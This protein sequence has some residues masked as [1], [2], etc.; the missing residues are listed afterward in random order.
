VFG[1]DL[2]RSKYQIEAIN[3]IHFRCWLDLK[4]SPFPKFLR[5]EKRG[6]LRSPFSLKEKGTGD[7]FFRSSIV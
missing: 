5:D 6:T 2:N 3:V 1:Q 7:E 4:N